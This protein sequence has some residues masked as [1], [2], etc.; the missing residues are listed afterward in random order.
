MTVQPRYIV[1]PGWRRLLT[2]MRLRPEEVL[3]VAGLSPDLFARRTASISASQYFQFWYGLERMTDRARLPFLVG[4]AV[5]MEA[6]DTPTFAALCSPTLLVALQRLSRFKPLTA[7]VAF[8][9]STARRRTTVTVEF[10]EA[11]GPIPASLRLAELVFLVRLARTGSRRSVVPLEVTLPE[12]VLDGRQ[13]ADFFGGVP[14]T[15]RVTRVVFSHEDSQRPF[16][17]ANDAVWK[18]LGPSLR[19]RLAP[20]RAPVALGAR[21]AAALL[22][23]LPAG[24]FSLPHIARRLAVSVRTLQRQL[25]VEGTSFAHVL[26]ATRIRLAR[27]Y[28]AQPTR[29]LTEIAYLLGFEEVGSFS[30]ACRHWTGRSP[31][32]LRGP[33]SL[34]R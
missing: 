21:V 1:Q 5:S 17:T 24:D 6:F 23:G 29:S 9:V 31:A 26:K 20:R 32:A 15:G 2:D 33:S 18:H 12:A 34:R 14:R 3:R 4:E 30:R 11:E 13:C 7:P 19:M 16:L 25:R 22:E 10:P 8:R 28:L 27:H